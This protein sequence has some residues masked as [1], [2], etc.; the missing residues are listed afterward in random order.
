MIFFC[1]LCT[2]D[3]ETGDIVSFESRMY[4]ESENEGN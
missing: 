1:I 4:Q 2:L 3:N